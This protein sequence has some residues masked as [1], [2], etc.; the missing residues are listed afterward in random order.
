MVSL[1]VEVVEQHPILLICADSLTR[2]VETPSLTQPVKPIIEQ[3]LFT[4]AFI[5]NVICGFGTLSGRL[6]LGGRV[7]SVYIRRNQ[8]RPT[9]G[10]TSP[11]NVHATTPTNANAQELRL[12]IPTWRF[13]CERLEEPVSQCRKRWLVSRLKRSHQME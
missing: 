8:M 13:C 10:Q 5:F 4:K 11:I 2:A 1:R 12:T 6:F 9:G 3:T 7:E